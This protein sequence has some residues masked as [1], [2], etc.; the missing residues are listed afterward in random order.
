MLDRFSIYYP[1]F[2][3]CLLIKII[4]LQYTNDSTLILSRNSLFNINKQNICFHCCKKLLKWEDE[5]KKR[6]SPIIQCS[7]TVQLFTP[8]DL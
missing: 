7:M 2:L 4:F 1:P 5:V 3:M 6:V 8:D